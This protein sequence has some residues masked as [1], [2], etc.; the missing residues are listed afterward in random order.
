MEINKKK[1]SNIWNHKR[2]KLYLITALSMCTDEEMADFFLSLLENST[3]R[4]IRGL[5]NCFNN[6]RAENKT[7]SCHRVRVPLSKRF[8]CANSVATTTRLSKWRGENAP[9]QHYALCHSQFILLDSAATLTPSP[10]VRA[11][12]KTPLNDNWLFS[13]ADISWHPSSILKKYQQLNIIPFI[14]G[15]L[16]EAAGRPILA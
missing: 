12:W 14:G 11:P 10:W 1:T 6:P 8:F 4:L 9:S 13:L 2:W 7:C 16:K 3:Q 15:V 5:D